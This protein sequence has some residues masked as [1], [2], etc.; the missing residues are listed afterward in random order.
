MKQLFQ[1]V[2]V[3]LVVAG[4]AMPALAEDLQPPPWRGQDF[5]TSQVWEFSALQSGQI[6]PDG[7]APG[8][9]PPLLSTQL[10]VEPMPGLTWASEY[11][12]YVDPI[13][14][15]VGY[16]VWPLSGTIDIVV[17]NY[18]PPNKKKLIWMQLTWAPMNQGTVFEPIVNVAPSPIGPPEIVPIDLGPDWQEWTYKWELDFN[19][20]DEMI[21]IEGDIWVDAIVIDTW[22]IPEPSTLVLLGMGALGLLA[23]ASR[24]RRS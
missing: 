4:L 19:P 14:G 5:T 21:H 3:I 23:Y 16:G 9:L 17:D 20:P 1:G 22:C 10:V 6:R 24:R 15:D 12:P 8:G 13:A 7:P 11:E 2:L 18:N